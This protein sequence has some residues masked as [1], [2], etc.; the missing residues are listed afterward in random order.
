MHTNNSLDI[1]TKSRIV[2]TL[3]QFHGI[4]SLFEANILLP[5]SDFIHIHSYNVL[6]YVAVY[7][8]IVHIV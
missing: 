1:Q 3:Y 8:N 6:V 2:G 4:K 5:Q 7:L